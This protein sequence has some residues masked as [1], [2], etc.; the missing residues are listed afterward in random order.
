MSAYLKN[1]K[2]FKGKF[3]DLLFDFFKSPLLLVFL[4]TFGAGMLHR[5]IT[6]KK[7]KNNLGKK[8]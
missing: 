4:T 7:K 8:D 1:V 5:Y 3:M 6:L 2:L